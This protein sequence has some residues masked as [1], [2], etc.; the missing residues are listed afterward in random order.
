MFKLQIVLN[1]LAG[2]CIRVFQCE[3]DVTTLLEYIIFSDCSI[4]VSDCSIRVSRSFL[5]ELCNL[6]IFLLLKLYYHLKMLA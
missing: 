1:S 6:W 4:R 3:S 5:T 2:C